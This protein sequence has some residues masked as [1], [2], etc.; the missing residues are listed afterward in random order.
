MTELSEETINRICA[1]FD[2]K[3]L[4]SFMTHS[5]KLYTKS[6]DACLPLVEKLR[7][8]SIKFTLDL[9]MYDKHIV[10]VWEKN[11]Y[12]KWFKTQDKSAPLALSTAIAIAI[13]ELKKG[14]IGGK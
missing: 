5:W 9:L 13:L 3:H 7:T 14:N 12:E 2:G 11:G 8:H 1:E 10:T 6:V 4:E